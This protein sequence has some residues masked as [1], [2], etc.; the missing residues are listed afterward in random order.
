[1]H[2]R[3]IHI[4]HKN[5]KPGYTLYTLHLLPMWEGEWEWGTQ[6]NPEK[7]GPHKNLGTNVHGSVIHNAQKVE[8]SQMSINWING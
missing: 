2:T 7:K 3:V 8:T 4:Y 5:I 1:M 6:I